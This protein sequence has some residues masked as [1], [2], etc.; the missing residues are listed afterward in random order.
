MKDSIWER[1]GLDHD[2]TNNTQLEN[3]ANSLCIQC[4]NI[5][6]LLASMMHE[7]LKARFAEVSLYISAHCARN[8]FIQVTQRVCHEKI[9]LF[10][11][12]SWSLILLINLQVVILNAIVLPKH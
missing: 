3:Q 6:Y 10:N 2:E 1:N 11:M 8:V 9:V 7:Q 5:L 12:S 4:N